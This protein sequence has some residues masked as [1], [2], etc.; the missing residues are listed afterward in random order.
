M[1]EIQ[2]RYAEKKTKGCY[3]ELNPILKYVQEKEKKPSIKK[4]LAEAKAQ[5]DKQ[6]KKSEKVKSAALEV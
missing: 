4:Q 1:F 5:A 2:R 6:P 3:R